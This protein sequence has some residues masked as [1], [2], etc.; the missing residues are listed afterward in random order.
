[1]GYYN[2]NAQIDAAIA[3]RCKLEKRGGGDEPLDSIPWLACYARHRHIYN[4]GG[5]HGHGHRAKADP[6]KVSPS[7]PGSLSHS[8]CS[9]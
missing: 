9:N 4:G 5:H 8:E 3:R 1:V 7:P 6:H 2:T